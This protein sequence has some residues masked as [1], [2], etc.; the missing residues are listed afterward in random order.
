MSWIL[1]SFLNG[2]LPSPGK[3]GLTGGLG[4]TFPGLPSNSRINNILIKSFNTKIAAL[5]IDSKRR[6]FPAEH[7]EPPRGLAALSI[8]EKKSTF[9]NLFIF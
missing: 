8:K 5:E 7:R 4:N 6:T 9:V 3:G 1:K 2:C